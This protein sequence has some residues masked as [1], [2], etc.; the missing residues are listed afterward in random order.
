MIAILDSGIAPEDQ[1]FSYWENIREVN[2]LSQQD[3]DENG[4]PDDRIGCNFISPNDFPTDDQ[5]SPFY[6][7]HGTHVTGLATGRFLS[8]PLAQAIAQRVRAMILKIADASGFVDNGAVNDAIV[9]AKNKGAKVV[10]MSF[11]GDF[12]ISIK[13]SIKEDDNRLYVVAA[14]NGDLNRRAL[15]LESNI[16]RFPAKLSRELDNVISV[17]AHDESGKLACF[18][19]YGRTTVDLAAPGVKIQ[20]TVVGG[21]VEQV[22]GTS[23]A[24]PLVSLTS[25]LLFSQGLLEPSL[26]KQRILVSVDFVPEYRGKLRSEGKLN[27]AKA[28]SIHDDVVEAQRR[29]TNAPSGQVCI[30]PG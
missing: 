22:S 29:R 2:G 4:Y 27:A 3:D 16:P 30:A 26:I 5:F 25:A 28:L 13:K 21:G 11:E 9:Y 20:S 17:A 7:S 23:Q 8:D 24:A 12:S 6:H 18:S 1:R 10:N 19:N 14:G 15:D